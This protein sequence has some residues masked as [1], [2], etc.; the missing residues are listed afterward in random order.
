MYTLNDYRS[1]SS[2]GAISADTYQRIQ[3]LMQRLNIDIRSQEPV[4][5]KERKS[6]NVPD[7][8]ESIRSFKPTV[9]Q[10][11]KSN[12]LSDIRSALNKISAKNY[13]AN[14]AIILG[15]TKEAY[16]TNPESLE[17]VANTIFDI[18]STNKFFSEMYAKLYKQVMA[19]F[20]EIFSKIL[21]TFL[22]NF[23]ST[24]KSVQY[25][26]QSKNYDEFCKYNKEN[27][28][29]KATSIFI[30]NLVKLEVVSMETAL[31]MI[32]ELLECIQTS[33][34]E[35][36][37]TNEVEEMTE[38]VFLLLTNHIDILKAI[39]RTV[40]EKLATAKPKD[41]PSLSSRAFFKYMALLEQL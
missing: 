36:G 33:I 30:T 15:K 18:A 19:E 20:P 39:D 9:I 29:R 28:K 38:N 11:A 7:S 2:E 21:A 22:D 40:I 16:E 32:E 35:S 6:R 26:D 12:V 8:W 34:L 10:D 3:S 31:S 23:T 4:R 25:V 14:Y 27:D 24:V 5:Q 41:Y 17:T 13:D 37:K 1:I